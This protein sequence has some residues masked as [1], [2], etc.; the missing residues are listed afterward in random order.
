MSSLFETTFNGVFFISIATITT[1]LIG[2]AIKYCLKSKCEK[3]SLCFGLF[4]INRRVDLEVQEELAQMELGMV[5]D[6]IHIEQPKQP[7]YNNNTPK[8]QNKK[9]KTENTEI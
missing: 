5:N 3:F 2:L 9:N 8:L 6:D 1:S 4:E 7:N